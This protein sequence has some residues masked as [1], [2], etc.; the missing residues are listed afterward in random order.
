MK[1]RDGGVACAHAAHCDR[2]RR[3]LVSLPS[4][5]QVPPPLT[6][7]WPLFWLLGRGDCWVSARVRS[8]LFV[9]RRP[10]RRR[11]RFAPQPRNGEIDIFEATGGIKADRF[12]ST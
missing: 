6:G 5:N 4:P 1:V 10:T 8:L 9:L 3:F 2:A 12:F 7:I 11:P